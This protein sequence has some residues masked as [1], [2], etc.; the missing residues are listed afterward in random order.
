MPPVAQGYNAWASFKEEVTFGTDAGGV[1]EFYGRVISENLKLAKNYK[2]M[3]GMSGPGTLLFYEGN[4]I[5]QGDIEVEFHYGNISKLFKWIFTDYAFA[6]DT[7]VPGAN[8]H[9]FTMTST[10]GTKTPFTIELHRDQPTDKVFL[11]TGATITQAVLTWNNEDLIRLK[12]TIIGQE[13]ISDQ[14]PNK[15]PVL[16]DFPTDRP[17]LWHHTA[18]WVVAAE[19]LDI[20]GGSLTINDNMTQDRFLMAQTTRQPLRGDNRMITG[21]VTAE[22]DDIAAYRDKF[23]AGVRGN[24]AITLDSTPLFITGSTPFLLVASG[25]NCLIQAA[26]PSVSGPGPIDLPLEFVLE[27]ATGEFQIQID[28]G[29]PTYA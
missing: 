6:V 16:A 3:P 5:V 1:R 7:P 2:K 18:P 15:V 22:F 4:R 9:T 10:G 28:N 8:Q 11:V 17:V 29:N 12:L 13:M 14:T 24:L 25:A 19:T 26:D 27:G 21:Q 20:K 23:E